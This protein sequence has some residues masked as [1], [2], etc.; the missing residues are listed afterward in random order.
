MKKCIVYGAGG[1][2]GDHL[3]R[4]LKAEGSYVFGVDVKSPPYERS[5]ADKF[6]IHDMRSGWAE[7]VFGLSVDEA[8]QLSA[9]MGGAGYV[10]SGD[11]DARI[12]CNNAL[13]NL[14]VLRLNAA[15]RIFFSSSACVYKENPDDPSCPEEL[16]YPANPDSDY[17]WEKLFA[18]RLYLAHARNGG[19]PTRIGRY[20]NIL[21]IRG[22]YEGGR[23]KAPAALCRKVARARGISSID[24]WGDGEQTRSFLYVDDCVEAT[25]ALMRSDVDIPLNIGSEEMIS[26]NKLAEMI[27]DISGKKLDLVHIEGPLGVRGRNSDN[28]LIK[29]RLGWEPKVGLRDGIERTYEWILRKVAENA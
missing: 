20:H 5:V 15:S 24:I 1:F 23:E 11:N 18:E 7:G 3:V 25:I 13:I 6:F 27:I 26:I 12:L 22:T 21:G 8:Y 17:G 10:F 4:R 14:N 19:V 16:A 9:D 28:R 2:I 29:E